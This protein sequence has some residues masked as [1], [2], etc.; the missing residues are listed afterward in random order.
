MPRPK[1]QAFR[2][3]EWIFDWKRSN[4]SAVSFWSAILL[5]GALFGCAILSLRVKMVEP[6]TLEAPQARV[7]HLSGKGW[8]RALAMEAKAQGPFP[9]RFEPSSWSGTRS[10]QSEILEASQPR[11]AVHQPRLLPLPDPGIQPPEMARRAEPVL[12]QR[13]LEISVPELTAALQ[14]SPVIS[15]VDGIRADELP[16]TPPKWVGPV[17]EGLAARSWKFLVELQS[18]GRVHQL[19][20]LAGGQELSPPELAA[21][22]RGAVFVNKARKEGR[23]WVAVAI[24]FQ[25]QNQADGTDPE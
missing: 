20:S 19:V 7:I 12:P 17:T 8:S 5:V 23:R 11:L 10:V 25:N 15:A 18:D 22:L 4:S 1:K 2:R 21:W 16:K 6:V 3:S 14:L 9:S 24:E 13:S